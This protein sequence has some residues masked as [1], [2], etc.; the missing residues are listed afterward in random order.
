MTRLL[1]C[2][3]LL[4]IWGPCFVRADETIRQLQEEL[5]KR[6]L[7]F[8]N[9]DGQTSPELAWA[10]TRYQKRKGFRVTGGIDQE[11][12]T[13]LH[14]QAAPIASTALP[15]VPVLKSDTAPALSK[16]QRAALQKEAEENLDLTPGP[17][18]P[19]ESPPPGQDLNPER[20]NG[21]V[22]DYLRDA[23]TE[24]IAA[25]IKYYA[26]PVQYFDDGAVAKEFVTED[27]RKYAKRW[28]ERKYSL[29]APVSFFA[30]GKEGET[31]IEF[32][33]AF[34]LRSKARTSKN[35]AVGR[36]KNRWT[37]RSEGDEL[38]IV[39]IREE[40]LRE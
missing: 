20:V 35:K 31:N 7:Y 27:T 8:G 38:K 24:N 22:R 11:T 3:C 10:L 29:E 13:S 36:T 39:A 12:A 28:P 16:A 37:V 34:E 33:I 5:R 2:L 1:S 18:P 23:E 26:F 32:T 25:Q 6:N 14:I 40:R 9:V 30:S 21:F 15:D 17:P 4:L 19:A